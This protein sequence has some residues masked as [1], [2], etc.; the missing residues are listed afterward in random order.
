MAENVRAGFIVVVDGKRYRFKEDST[1]AFNV[2][3]RLAKVDR[4]TDRASISL[5][6]IAKGEMVAFAF[7]DLKK[8]VEEAQ[9]KEE[10]T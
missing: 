3:L 10:R 2:Q 1:E 7:A 5:C 6:S 4:P 9:A 8:A